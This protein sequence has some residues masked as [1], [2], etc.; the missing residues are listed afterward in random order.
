[1]RFGM[2]VVAFVTTWY[3]FDQRRYAFWYRYGY[4]QNFETTPKSHTYTHAN[5]FFE[6]ETCATK[7]GFKMLE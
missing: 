3:T 2:N 1:M 5:T 7:A 4:G 6:E